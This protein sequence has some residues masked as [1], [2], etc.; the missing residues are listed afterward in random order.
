MS[1]AVIAVENLSKRYLIEHKPGTQGYKR[2]TAL[3]DVIGHEA[4]QPRAQG[5]RRGPRPTRSAR[6][7][8]SRSSGRS[9]M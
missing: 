3:R 9:R 8:K 7:M 4:A 1:E 5:D 6:S 2:Y